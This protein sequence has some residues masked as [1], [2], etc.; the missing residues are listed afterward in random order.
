VRHVFQKAQVA[1][2]HKGIKLME[3][4]IAQYSLEVV[5]QYMKYIQANAEEAVREMLCDISRKHGLGELGTVSAEDFMDDGSRI[6]LS[7]TIDRRDG[8][9]LFDFTGTSPEVYSNTNAP[10][11]VTYRAIIYCLRCQVKRDIPLNQ[12]CLNPIKIVIPRGCFLNPSADAA[13]VGGNVLTSQRVTDVVLRAFSACAASQGCLTSDHSVLVRDRGW[14][15]IQS[16]SVG[17]QVWSMDTETSGGT[18]SSV[19]AVHAEPILPPLVYRM[20]VRNS[21]SAARQGAGLP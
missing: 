15:P 11:A 1:A 7:L 19:T 8:S 13:V 17:E 9:A 2:N 18:W 5:Q 3:D 20:E 4:L 21:I 10:P 14:L 16:V 12:G 6:R